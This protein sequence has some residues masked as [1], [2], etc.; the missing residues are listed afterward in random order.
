MS[1]ADIISEKAESEKAEVTTQAGVAATPRRPAAG[2][3]LHLRGLRV[4]SDLTMA[5]LAVPLAYWVRFHV[6]PHYIPGGEPPDPQ[7]YAAAAPVLP[8]T[9]VVVFAFMTIYRWRRGVEFI[10]EFF[11]VARAM[12]V[13]GV[14]GLAEIGS[15]RD[16]TF[17]YSRLTFFYWLAGATVLILVARYGLR[18]YQQRLRGQGNAVDR[19]LVVGASAAADLVIQRIRM[20]PDYGYQLVGVLADELRPGTSM[21]G[22]DVLGRTN[23][24]R[25][26]VADHQVD[27]VFI[28]SPDLSHE[29]ILRLVESCR[30]EPVEF[31][32]VPG[33]LQVLTS[34]VVSDQLAGIPLLQLRRVLDISG[35]QATMKRAFDL[36]VGGLCLLAALPLMAVVALLIRVTSAGPVLL[37]QSRVGF[38]ERRF[39]MLKFRSMRKDAESRTG[40]VWA[41]ADDRRRTWLG[42]FLRRFSLDELPQLWNIVR[43]E[44]SL[45]GPRPERP[46]FVQQFKSTFDGYGDRHRTRPGLTGWA[47][48]NDLRGHTPVEE[49]LIYDLY[50]LENWSLAFDVK[51]IL[52][53]LVRVF[54]HKNAY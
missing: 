40:P 47:Q 36:V 27:Q 33:T 54:T 48:V 35:A 50:Y 30:D 12:L 28:A 23:D 42:H 6:Y 5:L 37:R 14:V 52:I 4:A 7:R 9:V 15:Y 11:S 19:A 45:V 2:G 17:T 16:G 29:R 24:V 10:D 3:G 18:V 21:C 51:I 39:E 38:D 25:Q 34:P 32:M 41:S 49:R 53:T 43:G 8:L 20:F 22:V 1:R 44:M 31:R 26:V 13:V 46:V